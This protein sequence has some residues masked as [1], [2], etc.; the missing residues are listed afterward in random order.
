M[1]TKKSSFKGKVAKDSK[2]QQSQGS[3]YGH[4]M[5]PKGVSVFN[6][7]PGS[8]IKLDFM[9]YEVSD[10]KH[11]DRDEK[12]EIAIEGSLWYKRPYFVHKNIGSGNDTVVCL[13]SIGKKCPICEYRVKRQKE[14]ADKEEL[15]ALKQ[16]KRVLYV[17]IPLDSKEHEVKPH[18]MD[19]SQFLFQNLLND[20]LEENEENGVFP[21]LEEG[22]SLKIRF[23]STTIGTSK[24]F[25]EASRIDFEERK[26]PYKETILEEIPDLDKVLKVLSYQEL[27]A[28]FLE[29]EAEAEED[30]DDKPKR[31]GKSAE[32]ERKTTNR[33][34]VDEDEEE[35]EEEEA[36]APKRKAKEEPAP[37]PKRKAKVVEPEEEEDEDEE[38]DEPDEVVLEWSDLEAMA[39]KH[40][41][42][43]C[44]DND[45]DVDPKDYDDD[46][47]SLRK[48]IATE[49][50]IEIPK[51]KK[52][53]APEPATK[54]K[55][56]APVASGKCPFKHKFGVD[57]DKFDECDSCK[58]WDDCLDAKENK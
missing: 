15:A 24:P 1:K 6:P 8:K 48:A 50:G 58:S 53:A 46:L 36:P 57:T 51:P 31:K 34:V 27:D 39:Y 44:K 33:K 42:I 19:I 21:D 11:P 16:S 22:L 17:V 23:D 14:G 40:M 38:E 9:P 3:S 45:L 20:E 29:M 13:A 28:K 37:A 43:L 5:L 25:A 26:K 18:I 2:R 12:E 54:G 7:K 55:A 49:L 30:E 35:E 47:V 52:K 4:L 56:D 41:K 10:L 32:P